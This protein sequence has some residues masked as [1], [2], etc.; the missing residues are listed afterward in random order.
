M[1]VCVCVREKLIC[2]QASGQKVELKSFLLSSKKPT[3]TLG[4][5]S[6]LKCGSSHPTFTWCVELF[7]SSQASAQ[8][9]AGDWP[10]LRGAAGVPLRGEGPHSQW[11][12]CGEASCWSCSRSREVCSEIRSPLGCCRPGVAEE[13]D[14]A[15]GSLGE[16]A[17]KRPKSSTALAGNRTRASRVAGENSTT[18]PPML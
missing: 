13:L 8:L 6:S 1:C 11:C 2:L 3:E 17:R 15:A 5:S 16:P 14:P 12:L 4:T 18:E 10:R 9:P 7:Y